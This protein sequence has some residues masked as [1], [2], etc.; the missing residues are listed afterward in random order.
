MPDEKV[1]VS[2]VF[3]NEG[4]LE[5]EY[6]HVSINDKL[7]YCTNNTCPSPEILLHKILATL[8]TPEQKLEVKKKEMEAHRVKAGELAAEV[9]RMM[10]ELT[11]KAAAA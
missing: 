10:L 4:I 7:S 8:P 3:T 9:E 6:W 1:R 5:R 2:H 11:G